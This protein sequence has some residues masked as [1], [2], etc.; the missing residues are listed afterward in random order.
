MFGVLALALFV[1]GFAQLL[2]TGADRTVSGPPTVT[3]SEEG[4]AA[5]W[6]F[7]FSDVATGGALSAMEAACFS[8]HKHEPMVDIQ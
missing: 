2:N 8:R 7:K 3:T 6:P 1:P 4:V 5:V